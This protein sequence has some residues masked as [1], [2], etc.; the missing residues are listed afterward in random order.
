M[1][2]MI[3]GKPDSGKSRMAEDMAVSLSGGNRKVYIA[4]MI[5]YGKEGQERIERHRKMREGKGFETIEC[6]RNLQRRFSGNEYA[7][8]TAIVECIAN[9]TSNV[10]FGESLLKDDLAEY[11]ASD[12]SALTKVFKN[13][14]IVS[15]NY[16]IK[17][18]YDL[19]TRKYIELI[20]K[21]ND[22]LKDSC[23]KVYELSEDGSFVETD[24]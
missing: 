7:D 6:P 22:L 21:V 2:S 17:E 19:E 13:L 18:D 20:G 12:V 3:I 24:K 8:S 14:V 15:N 10:L 1:V 16:E 5:P 4:T 9:L 23:D 11:I